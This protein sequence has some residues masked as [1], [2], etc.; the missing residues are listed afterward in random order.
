[1]L[2][3]TC[4]WLNK[5]ICY[6][7]SILEA[8]KDLLVTKEPSLSVASTLKCNFT[9]RKLKPLHEAFKTLSQNALLQLLISYTSNM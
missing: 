3:A 2:Q 8:L 1:M 7:I 4:N 5:T 9:E 6:L